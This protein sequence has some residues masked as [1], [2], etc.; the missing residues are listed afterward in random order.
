[1]HATDTEGMAMRQRDEIARALKAHGSAVW[2]MCILHLQ[3]RADAEDAYQETFLRYATADAT[4]FNDSEHEKAWLLRVASN[5]CI[6]MNKAARNRNLSLDAMETQ[7]EIASADA[8]DTPESFSNDVIR[9][10]QSLPD[11]PKTAL[12]LSTYEGYTAPEIAE[13]LDTPVNTVYSWIARGRKLLQEVL[14]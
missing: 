7:P 1:M 2:R 3:S 10:F 13:L 8:L 5:V 4:A 11:P 14:S 12:Y 9:A 6:D